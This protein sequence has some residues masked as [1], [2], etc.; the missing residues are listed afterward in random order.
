MI[1]KKRAIKPEQR[2]SDREAALRKAKEERKKAKEVKKLAK[3]A[4]GGAKK[5]EPRQKTQKSGKGR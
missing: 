4:A 5:N 3:P 1:N 2:K